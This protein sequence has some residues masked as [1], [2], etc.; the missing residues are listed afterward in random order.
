MAAHAGKYPLSTTYRE[1]VGDPESLMQ[2]RELENGEEGSI[3][4]R[5]TIAAAVLPRVW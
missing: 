5:S 1:V 2:A 3:A 4:V